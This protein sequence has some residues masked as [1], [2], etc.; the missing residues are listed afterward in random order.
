M[1]SFVINFITSNEDKSANFVLQSSKASLEE[2]THTEFVTKLNYLLGNEGKSPKGIFI[3]QIPEEWKNVFLSWLKTYTKKYPTLNSV[4]AL[5][6]ELSEG[7]CLGVLLDCFVDAVETKKLILKMQEIESGISTDK[8]IEE[9]NEQYSDLFK[10]YSLLNYPYTKTIRFGQQ[11]R[12]LRTCRYCGRTMSTGAV[13]KTDAH[14]ISNCLGNVCYFTNDECD[15]CNKK[16]GASIEQEFLKYMAFDRVISGQYEQFKQY[17]FKTNSFE[18]EVNPN[19]YN[20]ELHI[21]GNTNVHIKKDGSY[22]VDGGSIDFSDVYRAMVKFVLGM[23]PDTELIHF[24]KTIGWLNKKNTI[25]LPNIK[26]TIHEEPV[27]HPFINMF[28]RKSISDALPYLCAELHVLNHEFLF[29]VPGCKLDY[30]LYPQ[31]IM[32]DF[33]KLYK[34]KQKW[35]DIKI[36]ANQ[37]TNMYLHVYPNADRPK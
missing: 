11:K 21:K 18:L 5:V 4:I 8:Q 25:S 27:N 34:R 28:F 36:N 19:T 29:M 32:D 20:V 12:E 16:F 9:F 2:I 13:F 23:L 6:S 15:S 37:P 3:R 17:K 24:E 33:L 30:E 26:E 31:T 1:A 35:I 14:T 7:K 10:H 22:C